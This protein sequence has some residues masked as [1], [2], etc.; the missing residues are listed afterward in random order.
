MGFVTAGLLVYGTGYYYPPYVV[1]GRV[2][3]YFPYPYSYA[4]SV[5]YNPATGAWARGGTVY[6]PYG[7][8]ATA[9]TAYNPATGAWAHR[10]AGYLPY[11]RARAWA[12][13]KPRT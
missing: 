9:G 3:A 6:G 8:A 5:W 7:G 12:E 1:P 13:D 10:A 11:A 4:G 2:P